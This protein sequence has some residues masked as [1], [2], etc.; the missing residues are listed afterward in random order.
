MIYSKNMSDVG[1]HYVDFLYTF[2]R[3]PLVTTL[4]ELTIIFT[5]CTNGC[6]LIFEP[7]YAPIFDDY[8]IPARL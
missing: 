2:E 5:P 4:V 3:Y 7:N 8:A 1:T 6:E